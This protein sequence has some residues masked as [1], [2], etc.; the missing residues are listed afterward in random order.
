MRLDSQFT[1]C[2]DYLQKTDLSSMTYSLETRTPFLEKSLIEWSMELP[3]QFKVRGTKSK[4]LLKKLLYRYVPKN[5]VDRPKRG[6]G[7]PI[8]SWLRNQ[9]KDWAQEK[10]NNKKNYKNLPLNQE[11]LI[12]LFNLHLSGKRDAHPLIWASLMLLEFNKNLISE[13]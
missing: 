8:D 5:L 11:A 3:H 12:R 6:F 2:D 7:V 4:Y 10:I 9:L 13:K 1:L